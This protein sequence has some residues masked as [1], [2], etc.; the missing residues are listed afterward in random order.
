GLTWRKASRVRILKLLGRSANRPGSQRVDT[1]GTPGESPRYRRGDAL[2]TRSVRGPSQQYSDAPPLK[3]IAS[4]F[5]VIHDPAGMKPT[6]SCAIPFLL[7]STTVT[8]GVAVVS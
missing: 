2:R 8:L 4:I 5:R 1:N 6:V 7:A 3:S